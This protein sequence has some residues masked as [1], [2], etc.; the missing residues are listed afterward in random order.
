[1]EFIVHTLLVTI[2][3]DVVILIFSMHD[4]SV[5]E[6]MQ[7]IILIATGKLTMEGNQER[8]RWYIIMYTHI[9]RIIYACYEIKTVVSIINILC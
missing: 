1:M 4:H 5:F 2:I 8:E 6:H 3:I 9:I 7:S